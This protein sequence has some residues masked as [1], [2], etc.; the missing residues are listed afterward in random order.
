MR[1]AFVAVGAALA[2]AC[3]VSPTGEPDATAPS[4]EGPPS[5]LCDGKQELKLFVLILPQDGYRGSMVRIENGY[6]SLAIDGTCSYWMN[7]WHADP[8]ARDRPWRTGTLSAEEQLIFEEALPLDH[9]ERLQDCVIPAGTFDAPTRAIYSR[10]SST[11]CAGVGSLFDAAWDLV[12][13]RA[14]GLW[15][16]GVP[17]Q[18]AVHVSAVESGIL[19]GIREPYLWPLERPL[20][21]LLLDETDEATTEA[22]QLGVSTLIPQPDADLLRALNAQYLAEREETPGLFADGMQADDGTTIAVVYLRDALPYE[23]ESGL[24][25]FDAAR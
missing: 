22:F 5:R 14:E 8:S 13:S 25:S 18:G 19:P 1:F 12:A 24:L 11:G 17:M 9:L 10:T 6:P 4:E 23:D 3:T 20:A 16:A 15:A 21:E 2:A 7:P